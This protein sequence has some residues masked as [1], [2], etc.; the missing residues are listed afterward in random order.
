MNFSSPE[1]DLVNAVMVYA[2]RCRESGNLRALRSLNLGIKELEA[3]DS[4]SLS[5]LSRG[6]KKLRGHCLSI[7]VDQQA[8]WVMIDRLKHYRESEKLQREL[9][10]ADA[11]AEMLRALFGMGSKDYTR[12]CRELSVQ[13]TLGRPHERDEATEHRLW[14]AWQ[15]LENPDAIE[16]TDYLQLSKASELPVRTVWRLLSRWQDFPDMRR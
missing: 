9:I 13:A 12:Y 7:R 1:M 3:I 10:G 11:P 8:F 5:D 15:A 14:D 4:L 16:A 2:T 6:G